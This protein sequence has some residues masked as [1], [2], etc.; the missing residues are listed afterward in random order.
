MGT[1]K[2]YVTNSGVGEVSVL[3]T[4]KGEITGTVD[5]GLHPHGVAPSPD[6]RTVYVADTGPDTGA[7]GSR[8]LTVMDTGADKATVT[9]QTGLARRSFAVSP[10]GRMVYVSCGDGLKV[11]DA[12]TG[13]TRRRLPELAEANGVAVHT[14]GRRVYMVSP[15]SD[16]LVV[17]DAGSLRVVARSRVGRTPWQVAL[18]PDGSRAWVSCATDDTVTAVDTASAKADGTV[19]VG[20]V[21]TGIT[22]TSNTVWVC[23]NAGATVDA[24]DTTSLRVLVGTRLG[25]VLGPPRRGGRLTRRR[26]PAWAQ[27]RIAGP[28]GGRPALDGPGYGHL[29]MPT[30]SHSCQA[31]A[32]G[33]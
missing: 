10:D 12:E 25:L 8:T 3:D 32:A 7:G 20:H 1:G 26:T 5:V 16:T 13:R 2:L 14:D 18:S 6:G 22:A 29:S 11:L 33:P 15:W 24:I 19:K 4:T 23:T 28:A 9:W 30:T 21:P 31:T 17:L 27:T